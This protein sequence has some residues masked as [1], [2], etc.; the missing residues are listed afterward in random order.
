MTDNKII[1]Q[2]AYNPIVKTYIF[3]YVFF[4]L[5]VTIIGIP[6]AL[7]WVLGLGQWYSNQFYQKLYCV[8]TDKHLQFRMGIL[9]TI[10]K[11]I[12]VEN[13]QDLTFIE[14]PVLRYFNLSLLRVETA[15][16]A[17]AQGNQ[18]SLVGI[19][20]AHNFR[21]MVLEQREVARTRIAHESNPEIA[22]LLKRIAD[23]IDRIE[24]LIQQ[25]K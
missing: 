4:I 19:V 10:D 18:M 12:P 5:L 16:Q 17:H 13:I 11:T 9:F 25:K 7:L 14:G 3:L 20:D 24:K 15:G 6:I 22:I 1:F 2:A 8:L 21:Q 23:G